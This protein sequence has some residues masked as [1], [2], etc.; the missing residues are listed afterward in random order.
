MTFD[1]TA[2]ANDPGAGA[3]IRPSA[4]DRIR[5]WTALV[6]AAA[7]TA[8]ILT[9]LLYGLGLAMGFGTLGILAI[10]WLAVCV[11]VAVVFFLGAERRWLTARFGVRAPTSAERHA[12][13][14]AWERVAR[15]SG[16]ASSSHSLWIRE[17]ERE[18]LLPRRMIA[19][20]S[21]VLGAPPRQLE[22][23]LARELGYRSEGRVALCQFVFRY[24]NLPLVWLER[25]L[26]SGPAAVGAWLTRR[27][28]P[29][30]ARIFGIGWSAVSRVLV[31]CPAIAATTV[32][33]G[34]PAALLLRIAPEV[35][36]CA[37]VPVVRRIDYRADRAAVDLGYGTDLGVALQERRAESGDAAAL[38]ALSVSAYAPRTSVDERVRHIRD[39]MDERVRIAG[40]SGP[41]LPES[42]AAQGFT[43]TEG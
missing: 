38:Y 8:A 39:R 35:A 16:I 10:A 33:V 23:V 13:T 7:P 19:V 34:L 2:K 27:M 20:P 11:L 18:L 41:V 1:S 14:T 21:A 28:T 17:S 36:A 43:G 25:V 26:L 9:V 6:L 15:R 24:F 32:I 22:A 12:L 40:Y 42:G 4:T 31:A 37:L 29:P 5:S 30:A 3:A